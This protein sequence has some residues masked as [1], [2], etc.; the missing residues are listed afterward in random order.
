MMKFPMKGR[1]CVQDSRI[2]KIAYTELVLSIDM[3]LNNGKIALFYS[4]RSIKQRDCID[5]NTALI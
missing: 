3:K 1:K 2:K 4:L 5:G